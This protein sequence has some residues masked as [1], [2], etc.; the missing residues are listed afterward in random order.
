MALADCQIAMRASL[1]SGL[2]CL[3]IVYVSFMVFS[4]LSIVELSANGCDPQS[5]CAIGLPVHGFD[6]APSSQ[7]LKHFKRAIGQHMTVTCKAGDFADFA[8]F[9]PLM[10]NRST[11]RENVQNTLFVL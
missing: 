1:S 11:L 3:I 5:C 6:E 4:R 8:V 2:Y 9:A 10:M 7:A